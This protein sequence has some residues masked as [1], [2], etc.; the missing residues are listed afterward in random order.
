MAVTFT[1]KITKEILAQCKG[2]SAG[3]D[4]QTI[5]KNCAIAIAIKELFP[6]VFV[7]DNYIYPFG[8]VNNRDCIDLKI[9]MPKIAQDF[10]QVFDSLSPIPRVRLLLPEFEFEINIPDEVIAKID[11]EEVRSLTRRQSL[12][13]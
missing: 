3:D 6:E 1:I 10:I 12:Y 5:G 9:E 13:I 8:N 7:S 2:L 4:I 11:I